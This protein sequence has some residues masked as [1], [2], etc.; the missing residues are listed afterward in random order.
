MHGAG[1]T[2]RKKKKPKESERRKEGVL[3]AQ[4]PQRRRE[5][6]QLLTVRSLLDMSEQGSVFE[7]SGVALAPIPSPLMGLQL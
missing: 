7:A 6:E 4:A 5:K 2:T 1:T 3:L